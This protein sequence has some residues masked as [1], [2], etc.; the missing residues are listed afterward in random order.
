MAI[1]LFEK[2]VR[3]QRFSKVD[4]TRQHSQGCVTLETLRTLLVIGNLAD[5][6]TYDKHM[7]N[8]LARLK[9]YPRFLAVVTA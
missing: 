9:S 6:P 7:N 8:K 4:L 1:L 3:I 2:C 5:M